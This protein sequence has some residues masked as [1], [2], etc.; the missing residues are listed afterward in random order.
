MDEMIFGVQLPL[1]ISIA[2][3]AVAATSLFVAGFSSLTSLRDLRHSR[4]T[5]YTQLRPWVCYEETGIELITEASGQRH[6][7]F[8]VRW[9]NAGSTPARAV[10]L[11]LLGMAFSTAEEATGHAFEAVSVDPDLRG[12][13]GPGISLNSPTGTFRLQ[14]FRSD[15]TI[16]YSKVTYKDILSEETHESEVKLLVRSQNK[17]STESTF[18]YQVIHSIGT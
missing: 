12:I 8:Y 16:F 17:S 2:G 9:K 5:S 11:I 4:R 10:Q 6:L 18:F 3:A 7:A 15:S 14:D 1:A 13:I